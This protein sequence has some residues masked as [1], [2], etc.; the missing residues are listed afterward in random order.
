MF[1]I[2]SD[3]VIEIKNDAFSCC[4]SLMSVNFPNVITF[5]DMAFY[6]C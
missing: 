2:V 6:Y 1:N 3:S 5:G 4:T